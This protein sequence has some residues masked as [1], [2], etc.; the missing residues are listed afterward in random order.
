MWRLITYNSDQLFGWPRV[1]G[2]NSTLSNVSWLLIPYRQLAAP[3]TPIYHLCKLVHTYQEKKKIYI[4][5]YIYRCVM[6]TPITIRML[7][8]KKMFIFIF[9]WNNT[10]HI[11]IALNQGSILHTSTNYPKKDRKTKNI[12]PQ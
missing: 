4:Y 2:L 6:H 11:C 3:P 8:E 5:I 9:S 1:M 7:K 10:Q 12:I